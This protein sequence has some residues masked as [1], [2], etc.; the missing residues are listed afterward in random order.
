M[1]ITAST[2]RRPASGR[3]TAHAH[4]AWR[5]RCATGTV[6]INDHDKLIAEAETGGYRRN[7][8]G[9]LHGASALL[10]FVEIKHIDQNAGVAD[11]G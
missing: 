1:P 9:R 4:G 10:D 3:A 7:G 11:I 2:V 6:W 8:I 5:V